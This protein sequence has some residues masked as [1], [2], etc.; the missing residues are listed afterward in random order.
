[1]KKKTKKNQVKRT[2]GGFEWGS[3]SKPEARLIHKIAGRACEDDKRLSWLSLVMDLEVCHAKHHPLRLQEMLE[4]KDKFSF[5]H[6]IYMIVN[7]INRRTFG[8]DDIGVPR[9]AR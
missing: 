7:S 6:D 4:T 8:W 1:M 5:F 3:L 2:D 9:F